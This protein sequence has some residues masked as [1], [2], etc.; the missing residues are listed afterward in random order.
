MTIILSIDRVKISHLFSMRIFTQKILNFARRK[1]RPTTCVFLVISFS[2]SI[3][4]FFGP[5]FAN[6]ASSWGSFTACMGHGDI[7]R[8]IHWNVN[9]QLTFVYGRGLQTWTC[10]WQRW[11]VGYN[12]RSCCV[13]SDTILLYYV[14]NA[15][16]KNM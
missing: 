11:I 1:G 2:L 13:I 7:P 9:M 15:C 4:N 14:R 6:S 16:R 10:T 5:W 8:Q 3:F 12:E